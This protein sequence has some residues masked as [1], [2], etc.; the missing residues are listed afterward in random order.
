MTN[1]ND[2]Q[3]EQ[4]LIINKFFKED[5]VDDAINYII[6]NSIDPDIHEFSIHDYAALWL[7][8][9]AT[10]YFFEKITLLGGNPLGHSS[11][12]KSCIRRNKTKSIDYLL[13]NNVLNIFPN[14]I[15]YYI[16]LAIGYSNKHLFNIILN[17]LDITQYKL[18]ENNNPTCIN[19]VLQEEKVDFL[20]ILFEHN[21]IQPY[22]Y[23]QETPALLK[24][25][26]PEFQKTFLE[27]YDKYICIDLQ[28]HI[29]NINSDDIVNILKKIEKQILLED[30]PRATSSNHNR[31]KI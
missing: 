24:K 11:I 10:C 8:D 18:L 20:K 14:D 15:V 30:L 21:V 9:E 26:T 22:I 7:E 16:N 13:N 25:C 23:S 12:M 4:L 6:E 31:T 27:I 19:I 17:N 28:E 2:K 3:Y 29:T 5:N 1:N